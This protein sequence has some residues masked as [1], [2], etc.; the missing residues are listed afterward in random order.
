MALSLLGPL[1]VDGN[2]RLSPRDRVVLSALAVHAGD[3][4]PAERLADALWGEEPPASWP[5]VVQGSIVRLRR[6]LGRDAVQTTTGGYRLALGEDE[7]D[8]RRFERLVE[9]GR[10]LATREEHDRAAAT[11]EQALALWRGAPLADIE[12]WPDGRA[13][14]VRLDEL[15]QATEEALLDARLAAGHDVVAEASALVRAAPLREHRWWQLALG[16]YRAGRQSEALEA[17]RRARRTLQEDLGLDPGKELTD[18]EQDILQHAPALH[19]PTA[20]E[21]T[22]R[23]YCPWKGLLVYDRDDAD[24]FFGREPEVRA[25]LRALRGSPLLVVAGPSGCGKS[26]MVRA[27]LVPALVAAGDTATVMTPGTDPSAALVAAVASAHTSQVLVVDQLEELFTA[28]HQPAVVTA[29]LDQLVALTSSGTRVVAVVRADQLGGLSTSAGMARL[30]ERGLHLVTPMSTDGLR[31]AIEGPAAQAGLRLEPGL[32]ELLVRDIEDEPGALPLLSHAL[33]ETWVRRE[34]GVLTLDGYRSTGGIRGAVAQSAEQMWESLP[35]EQQDDVRA[36]WLRLVVP[37][38]GGEPTAVRLPLAVAAPDPQ[39]RRVVDLLVRCR[40]VTTDDRTV[41]VAHEAVIRAWPRLRSW[42]DEDSAGLL[43][44]RHL[45]VAAD[46]WDAR[47]RPDSELY[48]GARLE[49][50]L[51]WR[52]GSAP[53]AHRGGGRLPGR[54]R[55]ARAAADRAAAA[56]ADRHRVRAT[57]RLRLALVATALGLVLAL[58]AG[59]VAVQ[60]GRDASRTARDAL[61]D[62]LA[63]QSV[64]LRSTQRDLAALLAVEAYRLRPDARTRSALLGVFTARP[65]FLGYL[66]TGSAGAAR[67]AARAR[68]TSSPTAACSRSVST[69]SSGSVDLETGATRATL[70]AT[71]QPRRPA[72]CSA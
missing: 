68:D 59:T 29:F 67:R 35:P 37:T 1:Q 61:V 62:K 23:G 51:A 2:G 10:L 27:G 55:S 43:T 14:V 15:R 21:V 36:L 45:A 44:L 54:R 3:A 41:S 30:A 57:R 22:D 52:E 70:P 64:A 53:V 17:V 42:L 16:L 47:G 26:S 31:E 60:R 56:A 33:A 9:R 4:L 32:V 38:A 34:A 5:K 39:R 40:L 50:A 24:R 48:R 25:C 13:E 11:Y 69:A 49:S 46:D 18:L 8:I 6:S 65:G 12:D 28:G 19:G 58:V 7:I 71:G 66:P 72:H 20:A 63:A